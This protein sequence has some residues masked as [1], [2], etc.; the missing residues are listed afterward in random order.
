MQI[1][2]Q[3]HIDGLRIWTQ[4]KIMGERRKIYILLQDCEGHVLVDKSAVGLPPRSTPTPVSKGEVF[5]ALPHADQPKEKNRISLAGVERK[6]LRLQCE[7]KDIKKLTV[8]EAESLLALPSAA[9]RYEKF[10]TIQEVGR[11]AEQSVSNSKTTLN[12]FIFIFLPKP[13]VLVIR[14]RKISL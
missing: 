8:T 7:D 2:L 12:R 10:L 5:E 13:E 6:D 3:N 11:Q 1:S 9:L 14:N 4:T